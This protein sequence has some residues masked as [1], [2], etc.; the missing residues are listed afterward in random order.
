MREAIAVGNSELKL[1]A[2]VY[3][4]NFAR[5]D[6]NC[7]LMVQDSD[8]KIHE[9]LI[10][11][12][13][14]NSTSPALLHSAAGFLK[15]LAVFGPNKP[16]IG[17][18]G[19]IEAVSK[20]WATETHPEIQMAGISLVRVL[21]NKCIENTKRLLAPSSPG[22]DLQHPQTYLNS[23]LECYKKSDDVSIKTEIGRI[24][25]AA[26]RSLNLSTS[27]DSFEEMARLR[28]QFCTHSEV[29]G[30]LVGMVTQNKWAAVRSEGWFALSLMARSPEGIVAVCNIMNIKEVV[31]PLV[32]TLMRLKI[33]ENQE[34]DSV[35]AAR[36]VAA[37]V[38]DPD[39]DNCLV[40]ITALKNSNVSEA[41][42]LNPFRIPSRFNHDCIQEAQL[43]TPQRSLLGELL[44]TDGHVLPLYKEVVAAT[45]RH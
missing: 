38:Q 31:K 11:I 41:R 1:C 25:A 24:V 8:F 6:D 10:S 18:A 33:D 45:G 21:I 2:C 3:L 12:F 35:D 15:N 7:K 20:L 17:S 29:V 44:C 36:A 4:G 23:L 5:C 42:I 37:D 32:E 27:Q 13:A 22:Q 34:L 19:C 39:R 9:G 26:C 40:L 28:C 14:G 16:I 43:T 30:P